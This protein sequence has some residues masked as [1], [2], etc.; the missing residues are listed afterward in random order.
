LFPKGSWQCHS[1]DMF[2]SWLCVSGYPGT[3]M[4]KHQGW[5]TNLQKVQLLRVCGKC[6]PTL[7]FKYTISD[8]E[9]WSQVHVQHIAFLGA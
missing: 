2:F 5:V 3:S 9:W 7:Q 6:I 1:C 4:T 8:H